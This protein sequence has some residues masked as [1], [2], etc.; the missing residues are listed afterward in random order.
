MTAPLRVGLIGVGRHARQVLIPATQQIPEAL[1]LVA[2]ATAHEETAR[3][4]GEFYRLPCCVGH[5]A[6]LRHPE[7]DAVIIATGDRERHAIAALEAGKHVFCET[8]GIKSREGAARIRH[9]IRERSL[10]YQVG[11]C[12]RYAPVYR[13][14]KSLLSEWRQREPGPRTIVVRY[15]PFIGHFENLLLGLGGAIAQVLTVQHPDNSGALLLYRFVSGDLASIAW[16]SFH[17]VSLPFEAVEIVHRTGRLLAEDGRSLRFDCTPAAQATAAYA[18]TYEHA[19]ARLYNSTFSIPYGQNQQLYLRGYTP[20]LDDFARCV[21]DRAEPTCGIDDA[22]QTYLVRRAAEASHQA[23]G[24]WVPV[25]TD[26]ASC[27]SPG[28]AAVSSA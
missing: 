28:N 4:A 17:N 20:E 12:L 3:R 6:L 21:R 8:A 18:L 24:V 11:S 23:G 2:L 14:M 26:P 5:D 27:R 22:E 7:V 15:Y 10:T 1:R 16:C 19:D 25:A 13:K 9:L